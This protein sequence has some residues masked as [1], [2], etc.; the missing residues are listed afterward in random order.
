MTRMKSEVE[1]QDDG[2]PAIGWVYLTG[3]A[4]D[5]ETVTLNSRAYEFD[6]D[7]SITGDVAVDISGDATADAAITALVAAINADASRDFEAVAWGGNSDTTAGCSLIEKV[8]GGSNLTIATDAANGVVS[9]ANSTNAAAISPVNAWLVN[10][11][12]T[13]AD[14]TALARTG[15][16]SVVIGGVTSSTAPVFILGQIVT[17]AGALVVPVATLVFVTAQVNSNRYLV[18]VDDG[19]ATLAA[20]DVITGLLVVSL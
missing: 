11:T 15:G 8:T 9:A 10:Y 16:N 12:V 14:V 2:Y 4:S 3:S 6:T 5:T 17:T 1:W 13:A 19:A 7:S 20:G 18:H